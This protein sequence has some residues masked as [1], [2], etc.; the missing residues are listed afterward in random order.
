M[1]F[2]Y[3]KDYFIDLIID[4]SCSS[5]ESLYCPTINNIAKLVI[6]IKLKANRKLKKF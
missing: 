1:K 6:N 4:A 2:I 5:S 3:C